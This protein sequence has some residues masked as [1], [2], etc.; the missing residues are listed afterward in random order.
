MQGMVIEENEMQKGRNQKEDIK[1]EYPK[2]NKWLSY[3]YK[4]IVLNE[5]NAILGFILIYIF[6][7][8]P[9]LTISP[10]LPPQKLPVPS[11]LETPRDHSSTF[12][13]MYP[14]KQ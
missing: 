14:K 4:S 13:K 8:E 11:I 9:I 5:L 2:A 7:E 3:I 10:P 6:V 1:S 12:R